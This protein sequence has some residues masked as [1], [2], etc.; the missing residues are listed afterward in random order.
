MYFVP[1]EYKCDWCNHEFVWGQSDGHSAPVIK[2]GPVCPKCWE[3][4]LKENFG[5][6]KRKDN[7]HGK[8]EV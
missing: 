7:N 4:Y 1:Q 3:G 6:G 8:K 2:E 5:I